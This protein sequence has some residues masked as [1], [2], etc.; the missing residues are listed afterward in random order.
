MRCLTISRNQIGV[1]SYQP[2][3]ISVK[4]HRGGSQDIVSD[5]A[6]HLLHEFALGIGYA[7]HATSSVVIKPEGVIG[8]IG[9]DHLQCFFHKRVVRFFCHGA[10]S[11]AI[12]NLRG[13][14]SGRLS[15][16][17]VWAEIVRHSYGVSGRTRCFLSVYRQYRYEVF[18]SVQRSLQRTIR[19]RDRF[20]AILNSYSYYYDFCELL[21]PY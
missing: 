13:K 3:R 21:F 12:A 11:T 20:R 19:P 10:S 6:T 7:F 4:V 5:Q 14:P 2:R 9:L 1:E 8:H 17:G 18:S 16:C 15:H